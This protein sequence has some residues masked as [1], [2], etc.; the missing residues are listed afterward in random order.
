MFSRALVAL[1]L[2]SLGAVAC[3]GP[4]S[5]D[6]D[7]DYD[8]IGIVEQE[9]VVCPDG[10][11][12]LGIDVSHHQGTINWTSVK[13]AGVRFAFVRVS[14]GTGT[15]DTQFFNNWNGAKNAGV[16]RGAYQFFRPSQDPIAQADLLLSRM[17]T[18]QPGDLPPVIDV[19]VTS[20]Q[21]PAVIAQ[22]V[23]QWIARVESVTGRKPI[24]YT[25]KFF[26]NDN[27]QSSAFASYPL[28]IAQYTSNTCPDL[29]TPWSD[30]SFFQ[31][32]D[33]GTVA[34]ISG[35]VD[36][37]RFNGDLNALLAFANGTST[38]AACDIIP[39][40]GDTIDEEDGC[41]TLGGAPQFL[42]SESGAG[43]N[44]S[45]VWTGATSSANESNFAQ[46]NLNF[47]QG[48]TYKVE[49]YTDPAFARSTKAK[50]QIRHNGFT[51]NVLVNQTSANGF[52]NL[53]NFQFAAG[54]NQFIHLGDN[55]GEAS[56]LGVK[57]AFDAV[58]VT[59]VDTLPC[60][61]VGTQLTLDEA[62]TCVTLGGPAQ[63][64]RSV[65]GEGFGNAMVWTGTT[66]STSAANFAQWN[67]NF[68][69]AGSYKVEV[70]TDITVSRS[71]K[72]KYQI[73]H[74]GVTDSVLV[75]QTSANGFRTLG[76]FSF[77]A[78]A[79][80]FVFLGDNT[81]EAGG[82]QLGIDA[83]RVTR[84][85]ALGLVDDF[86]GEESFDEETGAVVEATACAVSPAQ[87][88]S[89]WAWLVVGFGLI[90]IRRRRA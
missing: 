31:F 61:T 69:Q 89:A 28:W 20:S 55:T 49:V 77:A 4:N 27:V 54:A 53:G 76:T 48:G 51:D 19:E 81:G 50:Y 2:V 13:N 15:L 71:T 25:G 26:W 80:Q 29:P 5:I 83:I 82:I 86:G 87:S 58:R 30:W 38:P 10:P 44:S 57:L 23:G 68:S 18:L 78:G 64:L 88:G 36:T 11:T 1:S 52:R 8:N 9:A 74:N 75:N 42:H 35:P 79:N 56:S 16:I 63:F 17:G 70:Y 73:R 32:T 6:A 65:T 60:G 46:W 12:T 45:L 37:N 33:S 85:A 43:F 14:D 84:V 66:A 40:T 34:G 24:V 21:T 47:A 59:R 62:E 7:R 3:A 22:K 90:L 72:A 41:V 67:L 39:S